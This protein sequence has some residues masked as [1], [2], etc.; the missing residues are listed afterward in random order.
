MN[1][2]AQ[3]HSLYLRQHANNPVDW[4]PWGVAALAAAQAADK[5][6][7]IS[8]G[9]SSCHWCHVM[10]HESF[11][12]QNTADYLNQHFISIKIDRE[13]YPEVDARYMTALLLIH[14]HG[15]WPMSVFALPDG[16]P[17]FAGTYF[18]KTP[19]YGQPAF[20]ELLQ[21]IVHVWQ[22]ERERLMADAVNISQGVYTR[23]LPLP[24]VDLD[25]SG[26]GYVITASLEHV[27]HLAGG[28]QG[29]PKFPPHS[30]LRLWLYGQSLGIQTPELDLA[31]RKTLDGLAWSALRDQLGGC[32]HRYSVDAE[33]RVPHFEQMLYDNAQLLD[34]YARAVQI[35]G[36][37]A[38]RHVLKQLLLELRSEW[39]T[40]GGWA[41]A[42]WDADDAGGEGGYYT[43]TPDE[44]RAALFDDAPWAAKFY[45]VE[46]AGPVE[47]RSTLHPRCC[48]SRPDN[49]NEVADD[50]WARLKHINRVLA[51]ARRGRPRPAR[52]DKGIVADNG[53]LLAALTQ[54][55]RVFGAQELKPWQTFAIRLRELATTNLPRVFYINDQRGQAGLLDY[56]ALGRGLLH[57]GLLNDDVTFVAASQALAK[58]TLANFN[59]QGWPNALANSGIDQHLGKPQSTQDGQQPSAQA[60]T[61]EWLLEWATISGDTSWRDAAEQIVHQTSGAMARYPIMHKDLWRVFH[62]MANGLGVVILHGEKTDSWHG[63]LLGRSHP[64]LLW[65]RPKVSQ[66]LLE[67]GA[68]SLQERPAGRAYYCQ[69]YVC[70]EPASSLSELAEQ[71]PPPRPVKIANNRNNGEH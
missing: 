16:R 39:L 41:A 9:Y 10:A 26:I 21:R 22:N 14:G 31:V 63:P 30:D 53:L 18:P 49:E 42:A 15:G 43:W 3:E 11:E 56:A 66:W 59:D 61:L 12:D 38:D 1:R 52:D 54:V 68:P 45:R 64:D 5:P 4:W 48:P 2:L 46:T 65:V 8:S 47:G 34:I 13:E 20:L 51:E 67:Q 19:R 70:Q 25:P 24:A 40:E 62:R 23:S 37:M 33:W 27:D 17:F 60:L 6:L 50:L 7:F 55:A 69:G 35:H 57:F 28:H 44:L 58:H 29:A 32:F 36:D 71:V